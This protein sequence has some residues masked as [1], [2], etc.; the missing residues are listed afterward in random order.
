MKNFKRMFMFLLLFMMSLISI[1]T[2]NDSLFFRYSI[3]KKYDSMYNNIFNNGLFY[4]RS[5]EKFVK[6]GNVKELNDFNNNVYHL[7]EFNPVGYI[8][9]NDDYSMIL[10]NSIEA[11]SPY[12]NYS[13]NLLYFGFLN[14]FYNGSDNCITN[15]TDNYTI[16]LNDSNKERLKNASSLLDDRIK[17]TSK[18]KSDASNLK[19]QLPDE[20]AVLNSQ[21]TITM[22]NTTNFLNNNCGYISGALIIYYAANVWG[23]SYLYSGYYISNQLVTDIQNGR[24]GPS[25]SANLEDAL[26]DYMN[27]H[28]DPHS[29]KVNMWFNPAVHTI[30]D[31]VEEDKPVV[32]YCDLISPINGNQISHSVVVHKV[33]RSVETLFFGIRNHFDYVLSVHMGYGNAYN[34]VQVAFDTMSISGLVNLHKSSDDL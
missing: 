5:Y 16:E 25:N 13:N 26:N 4:N 30:F 1:Y 12:K 27:A 14:Y 29:A 9:Y 15:I 33:K 17:S 2:V 10:E 7:I 11:E 21:S 32:I 19:S 18:K 20:Y 8:I 3:D 31:R 28:N 24:P 34:N 23:R 6:I 22:A